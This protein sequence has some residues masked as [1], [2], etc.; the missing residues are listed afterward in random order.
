M[1]TTSIP[2]NIN[3]LS[4]NGFKF[5][6]Q[7]LPDVTFFAQQVNLPGITLG[8]PTFATPFST[9]PIPG[10]T[11]S[12][13]GLT[14]N[15]LVDESMSNYKVIYN[16]IVALGFPE[17][18]EQ[19]IAGNADNTIS[20]GDLAKNYSD[21]TLQILDSNNQAIQTI[22]FFDVFPA[23]LESLSFASTNDGVNYLIGSTTF[24]Y[25]WYKFL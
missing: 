17:N 18:Y 6:I 11:L 5:A 3:P 8:E 23:S 1:T 14:L 22:Q 21:A 7:K 13:D 20:Y 25:G 9:Q 10:D 16:W 12:Y 19:Y 15:F 4:P 24:R 2:L